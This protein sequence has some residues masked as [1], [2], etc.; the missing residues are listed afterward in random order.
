ARPKVDRT[1]KLPS[2]PPPPPPEAE[3]GRR[4]ALTPD[5]FHYEDVVKYI[6]EGAVVPILGSGVNASDRS[7]GWTEGCGSLPDADEL[8]DGLARRWNIASEGDLAHV[9]QYVTVT[10]GSSDLSRALTQILGSECPPS[11]VHQ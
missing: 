4:V 10:E 8:A 5:S 1:V 7:S 11:S 3:P 2:P 6:V 9:A